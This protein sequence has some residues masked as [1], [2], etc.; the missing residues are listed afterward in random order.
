MHGLR[1]WADRKLDDVFMVSINRMFWLI[2]S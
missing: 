2:R 1:L